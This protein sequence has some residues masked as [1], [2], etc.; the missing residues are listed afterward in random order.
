MIIITVRLGVIIRNDLSPGYVISMFFVSFG[1]FNLI[2]AKGRLS[3]PNALYSHI[4]IGYIQNLPFA[5]TESLLH[6][7]KS[8]GEILQD[9]DTQQ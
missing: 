2:H 1:R 4:N 6:F 5:R 9:D 3:I 7:F 8:G